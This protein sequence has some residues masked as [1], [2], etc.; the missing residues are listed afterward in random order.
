MGL[1]QFAAASSPGVQSACDSQI[2][3]PR[4]NCSGLRGSEELTARREGMEGSIL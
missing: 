3:F 4:G 2:P 1:S